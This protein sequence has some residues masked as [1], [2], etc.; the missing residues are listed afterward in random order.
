LGLSYPGHSRIHALNI[1]ERRVLAS[2][3]QH[4]PTIYRDFVQW[5][6]YNPGSITPGFSEFELYY[7]H[8]EQRMGLCYRDLPPILM[9]YDSP[10]LFL[11]GCDQRHSVLLGYDPDLRALGWHP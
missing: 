10:A 5:D 3:E 1:F 11:E 8:A 2:F 6:R 7:S 9:G 4:Y